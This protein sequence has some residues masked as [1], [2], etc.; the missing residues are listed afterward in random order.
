MIGRS[1]VT[2]NAL[3]H[4]ALPKYISRLKDG[5]VAASIIADTLT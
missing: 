3:L 4:S 1:R 2:P 5:M